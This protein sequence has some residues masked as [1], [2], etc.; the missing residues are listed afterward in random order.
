MSDIKAQ[1]PG[2]VP[3]ASTDAVGNT[4]SSKGSS[5]RVAFNSDGDAVW[6]WK[7]ENGQFSRDVSTTRL[8]KLQVPELSIEKTAVVEQ[9]KD[10]SRNEPALPGGG[11]N[12]YERSTVKSVAQVTKKPAVV[13]SPSKPL[14]KPTEK[15]AAALAR[16][17][18]W[19]GRK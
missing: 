9:L 17:R 15:P 1:S 6:E 12:P 3:P 11:Y 5:G 8:H 14:V 4:P 7:T 19:L 10:P 16:A 2:S 18:A 13:R